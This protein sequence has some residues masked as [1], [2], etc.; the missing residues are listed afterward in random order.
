MELQL[1]KGP[2]KNPLVHQNTKIASLLLYLLRCRSNTLYIT[3]ADH[4]ETQATPSSSDSVSIVDF[5]SDNESLNT[6]TS[7]TG[8]SVYSRLRCARSIEDLASLPRANQIRSAGPTGP[9]TWPRLG[10]FLLFFF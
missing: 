8:N 7:T 10:S 9:R 3:M 2:E 4:L 6:T 5:S 1:P